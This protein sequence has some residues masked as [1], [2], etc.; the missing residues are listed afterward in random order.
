MKSFGPVATT[1]STSSTI[2]T[3]GDRL[4]RDRALDRRRP[5]VDARRDLARLGGVPGALAHA[6]DHRVDLPPATRWPE[7]TSRSRAAPA[8][9]IVASRRARGCRP[10]GRALSCDDGL[11]VRVDDAAHRGE[12]RGLRRPVAEPRS[13][14]DA[15]A[16]PDGEERLRGRRGDATRCGAHRVEPDRRACPRERRRQHAAASAVRRARAAARSAAATRSRH[17]PM[18]PYLCSFSMSAGRETP[19]LRAVSLWL[20]PAA[21]ERLGDERPLERLDA[22]AK[23]VSRARDRPRPSSASTR[24]TRRPTAIARAPA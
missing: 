1:G 5:R 21:L 3:R 18:S 16:G 23:R 14:D 13:P 22:A 8:S 4:A 10:P 6:D 12:L 20:R 15:V 9:R 24:A 19:S 17:R 7:T 2:R 11:E